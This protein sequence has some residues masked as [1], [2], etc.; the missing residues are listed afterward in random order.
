MLR[1]MHKFTQLISTDRDLSPKR[2][3]A[4]GLL[5]GDAVLKTEERKSRHSQ[6]SCHPTCADESCFLSCY[7]SESVMNILVRFSLC[8]QARISLG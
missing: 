2:Y 8:T 3:H 7:F 5:V 6:G 1:N 4:A